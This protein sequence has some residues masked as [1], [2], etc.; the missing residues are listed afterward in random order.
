MEKLTSI[1]ALIALTALTAWGATEDRT[2]ELERV[3]AAG[4]VLNEIMAAP[5]KGIPAEILTSAECVAIVPSM[6]K[7][8]F[9][10]GANYGKGVATCHTSKG[11]WSAPAPFRIEGGSWGLQIGGQAVDL[12]MLVMNQ[13]GMDNLLKSKFKI[14]AD[15]SAAAGPVG[16]HTEGTTDWKMRAQVLTYSRARGAFAGITL[17]GAVVKQ[18]TDDTVALYGKQVPF[19]L[20]LSGQVSPPPGTQTFLA[21]VSKHFREARAGERAEAA[22]PQTTA[23]QTSTSGGTSGTAT[24]PATSPQTGAA[25]TGSVGAS[26]QSNRQT[27]TGVTTETQ[28]Q[29]GTSTQAQPQTGTSPSQEN[30]GASEVKQRIE[31]ALHEEPNLSSGDIVVAVTDD[32]V[33]LSGSVPNQ[34]DK[35]AARRIAQQNAGNRV[36]VDDKLIVK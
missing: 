16:R 8:G 23:A 30:A 2:K 29:T 32:T 36:V 5:D 18:D 25:A 6:L 19:D 9:I 27:S 35:L 15:A 7:G 33:A 22:K 12:V 10:F 28:S 20:I 21:E 34:A 31:K 26:A 24:T 14:G 17:N 11:T 3:Q 13:Q 1:I 4:K